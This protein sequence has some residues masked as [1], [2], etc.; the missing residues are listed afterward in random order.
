VS[1]SGIGDGVGK[2]S[3]TPSRLG[4]ALP[5]TWGSYLRSVTPADRLR[6]GCLRC[7][8]P[9]REGAR[10]V[11]EVCDTLAGVCAEGI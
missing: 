2:L 10:K 4:D 7:M 9:L 5:I 3:A 6:G 1:K 8:I 11:S